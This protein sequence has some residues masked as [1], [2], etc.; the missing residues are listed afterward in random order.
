MWKKVI[1]LLGVLLLS[2]ALLFGFIG[3]DNALMAE[4]GNIVKVNYIGTLEDGTVFDSSK[5]DGREPLEFS[6]GEGSYLANFE[7]AVNGMRVGDKKTI[8]IPADK[9]YGQHLDELVIVVDRSELS[10]DLSNVA[11]GQDLTMQHP[12]AGTVNVI[13]VAVS[14]TTITI[15][16]NHPL[17]DKDLTF[18]IELLEIS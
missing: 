8:I 17:A 4:N 3:D 10:A 12:T 2:A 15:D 5:E 1:V 7:E 14:E 13:V 11:V 6:V 16:A 18:E 9:A